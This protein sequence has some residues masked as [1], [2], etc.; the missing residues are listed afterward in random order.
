MPDALLW[1]ALAVCLTT[2]AL[3]L[4][5]LALRPLL[6]KF[7]S[8]RFLTALWALLA[9]RL[10]LPFAVPLPENA[11]LFKFYPPAQHTASAAPVETPDL[12]GSAVHSPIR[13]QISSSDTVFIDQ[14]VF[15]SENGDT[16]TLQDT[17]DSVF[18]GTPKTST[19]T[20]LPW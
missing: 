5:L 14:P 10:M 12:P 4:M 8:P 7:L 15:P 16:E 11:V 20:A 6:G 1:T 18:Q 13:G 9:L 3:I 2:S 19:G 17:S